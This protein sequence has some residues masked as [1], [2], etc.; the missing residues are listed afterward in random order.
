M[1]TMK[2]IIIISVMLLLSSNNGGQ[3]LTPAVRTKIELPESDSAPTPNNDE[4]NRTI[5]RLTSTIDEGKEVIRKIS[6]NAAKKPVKKPDTV[7]KYVPVIIVDCPD[8][9]AYKPS[10]WRKLTNIF[11]RKK[12]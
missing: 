5:N 12:K 7:V 6:R 10:F 4:L 11:S 3:V 9:I 8:T 2:S 1:N